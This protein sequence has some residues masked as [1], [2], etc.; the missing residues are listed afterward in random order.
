MWRKD[1]DLSWRNK[2]LSAL[3]SFHFATRYQVETLT[4][5]NQ[6]GENSGLENWKISKNKLPVITKRVPILC[7]WSH[8]ANWPIFYSR[9][10]AT[11]ACSLH[12]FSAWTCKDANAWENLKE[13]LSE[14]RFS[15]KGNF[16]GSKKSKNAFVKL[17]LSCAQ[18]F[19]AIN[20]GTLKTETNTCTVEK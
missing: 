12:L 4:K 1:I 18:F 7:K 15:C 19:R 13:A 5:L 10:S 16:A 8:I 14:M 3:V 6:F 20:F 11:L 9:F 2:C 17:V